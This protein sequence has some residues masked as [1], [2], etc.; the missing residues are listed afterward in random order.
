MVELHKKDI[1]VFLNN[2]LLYYLYHTDIPIPPAE[3]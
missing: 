3:L 1:E 2:I